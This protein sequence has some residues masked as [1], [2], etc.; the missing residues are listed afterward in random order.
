MQAHFGVGTH[1]RQRDRHTGADVQS[2]VVAMVGDV[3]QPHPADDIGT[4]LRLRCVID[5]VDESRDGGAVRR[6]GR[7]LLVAEVLVQE[8]RP[9]AEGLARRPELGHPNEIE[10]GHAI[11]GDAAGGNGDAAADAEDRKRN[12]LYA[13]GLCDERRR[14]EQKRGSHQRRENDESWHD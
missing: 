8:L 6:R 5:D 14:R 11:L 10:A 1:A 2:R 13:A 3:V 4:H 7:V 12:R 9:D